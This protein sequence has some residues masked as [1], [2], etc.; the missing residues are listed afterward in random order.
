MMKKLLVLIMVLGM[1]TMAQ[2]GLVFQAAVTD[3]NPSDNILITLSSGTEMVQGFAIDAI[4]SSNGG[5]AAGP[6]AMPAAFEVQ[7]VGNI[8]NGM[9][10]GQYVLVDII[11]AS[12]T[13]PI[14]APGV[15]GVIYSFMYHVPDLPASSIITIGT[16][17]DD[18]TYL[19]PEYTV[20]MGG[21]TFVGNEYFTP[22]VLHVIPEPMTIGLL[23]LG[24]LFL[25]RRK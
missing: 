25:R 2:A 7:S 22:L 4:I 20:A 11:G 8:I 10:A 19:A 3:V 9:N 18:L 16:F 12:D 1:V 15:S 24:G 14:P 21:G 13:A 6:L 23:G 5:L 17:W